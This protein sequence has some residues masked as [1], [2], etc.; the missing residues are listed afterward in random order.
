MTITVADTAP[1][2]GDDAFTVLAGGSLNLPPPPGVLANDT[3][4]DGDAADGR[5]WPA[6]PANGTLTPNADGSFTYTPDPATS[7]PTPSPTRPA[8]ACSAATWPR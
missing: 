4:A 1:V 8:T 5:W 3:D 7:A 2:A 6:G